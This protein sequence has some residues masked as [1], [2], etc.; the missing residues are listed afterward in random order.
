M[1]KIF[2]TV[3]ILPLI[4]L[5]CSETIYEADQQMNETRAVLSKSEPYSFQ[6]I[7]EPSNWKRYTSLHE[8]LAA[9]QMPEEAR[10][11]ISTED[12]V[13]TCLNYP[14]YFHFLIWQSE[15]PLI[16]YYKR[17]NS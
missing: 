3:F 13:S 9:L 7:I 14:L 5:S 11:A 8:M 4:L 12:L 17:I 1:K 15:I 2:V 10:T 16:S 6:K